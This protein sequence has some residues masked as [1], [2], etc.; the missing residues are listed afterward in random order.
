MPRINASW[1]APPRLKIS[2]G[3][4]HFSQYLQIV[5]LDMIRL[6]MDRWF[7]ADESRFPVRSRMATLGF[8]YDLQEW[9]RVTVERSEEH[10]SELQSRGHLVCRL[11]L[12]KKK[13]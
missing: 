1:Q 4:G 9:G 8:G 2:A 3:Y 10:T 5:G 6:P 13:T 12:E 11:L 7:W